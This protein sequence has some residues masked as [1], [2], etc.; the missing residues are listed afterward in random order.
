[1]YGVVA[2]LVGLV[3]VVGAVSSLQNAFRR[4]PW[5]LNVDHLTARAYLQHYSP[6]TP[7]G[8]QRSGV[9]VS[10]LSGNGHP[11]TTSFWALPLAPLEIHVAGRVLGGVTFFLIFIEALIAMRLLGIPAPL[12]S[13]WLLWAYVMST[14]FMDYHVGVGQISGLIGFF[15]FVAWWA[16]RAGRD[17]VSGAA[18]GAACT[19]KLFPGVMVLFLVVTRRWR[20]VA[21]AVGIYLAIAATMT[22]R[23]GFGAWKRFFSVQAAIADLWMGDVQNQSLHGIVARLFEPVCVHHG[24]VMAKAMAI[25]TMLCLVMLGLAVWW[26][27][28]HARTLD[29]Y[30]LSFALFV[31]LSVLMSQWVWEHYTVIYLLPALVLFAQLWRRIHRRGGGVVPWILMALLGSVVACWRAPLHTK[32]ELQRR[33]LAGATDH[34]IQLHL[35][36]LLN[37]APGVVLL[38]LLFVA[39]WRRLDLPAKEPGDASNEA[40]TSPPAIS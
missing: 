28:K 25:S 32:Q 13:A 26:T 23:F 12:I 37:W 19:L 10:G 34:H 6:F 40:A 1:M 20:A 5:D 29:G 18:I 27:W 36:D 7:E 22:A 38:I 30:D 39:C 14:E 35:Y 17:L 31:T 3:L 24:P 8:A 4:T 11:P 16:G 9:A 21:G 33:V 2:A 15:F